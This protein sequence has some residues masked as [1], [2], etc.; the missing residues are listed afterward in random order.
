MP[1]LV[2]LL[3]QLDLIT[4]VRY[5]LSLATVFNISLLRLLSW[6]LVPYLVQIDLLVA[7]HR[8]AFSFRLVIGLYYSLVYPGQCFRMKH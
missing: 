3:L 8:F 5:H 4:L 7:V 2:K 1:S 6:P